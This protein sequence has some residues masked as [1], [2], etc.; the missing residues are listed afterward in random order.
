[1][2]TSTAAAPGATWA[3]PQHRS[4]G[5]ALRRGIVLPG[6]SLVIPGTAQLAAGN[7][8]VGRLGVRVWLTILGLIALTLLVFVFFR[9]FVTGAIYHT[10]TLTVLA[11]VVLALGL[12]WTLLVLDGWR[13][14]NPRA[15][16]PQGR[17]I[18]GLLALVMAAIPAASAWGM[19]G[20]LTANARV[21]GSIFGGGGTTQANNGRY[22]VLLLGGDAGAGRVGLRPDSMTVAS[23]DAQTGR[24]VLFSLPRNLQWAPFP[25]DSPLHK[26]YPNGYWCASQECLLN[27]VYTLAEQ[28][29][30]LFPGVKYPGVEATK[31]VI[32]EIL[33]LEINYW[34]MIDMKGFRKLIDAVGGIRLDIGKRVP[35]GSLHG[36][37]GV[38]GWIEPGKNVKLDG[39][40]ALWFARSREYS[41]DYERMTRQKCVMNAMLK[42]LNPTTVVTKFQ[43]IAAA[44]EQ[45]VATNLPTSEIPTML[46]LA[47]KG[48]ALPMGSV[49]FTPPLI[50]PVK[51]DFPKIRTVVADKIAASEAMDAS[52]SAMASPTTSGSASPKPTKTATSK[53]QTDNLDAICKV[54]S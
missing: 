14:A 3:S 10:A 19:S 15:M 47:M 21:A 26:K 34:A 22:N 29:K 35:M 30:K 7:K 31:G 53:T 27:A 50:K 36:S 17:I 33:G 5:V 42:Q 4:E 52:P 12:G 37:A 2:A 20:F 48:K 39:Y 54:S 11:W 46:E 8:A 23:I 38:F 40:H 44:G 18:S 24:T 9:S 49:S 41:T 43:D 32:E 45:I 1:M 16:S 6:M 25:A 28:N 51:P 13:I